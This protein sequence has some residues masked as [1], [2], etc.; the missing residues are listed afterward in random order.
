[1]AGWRKA[2]AGLAVFLGV[3]ALAVPMVVSAQTTT[4]WRASLAGINEVPSVTTTA[5]GTFTATLDETAGTLAWT[6]AV[7]NIT[8][9]TQAH[10]HSGAVG[11]N[12]PIVVNLFAAPASGPTSSINVSGTA[13]AADVIGPLAGNFAGLVSAIKAGTAYV[14]VHTSAN[15]GGEIRAQIGPGGTPTPTATATATATP[16]ATAT[17]KAATPTPTAAAATATV[18]AAPKSGTGFGGGDG[19][20]LLWTLG[21]LAVVS[22]GI[23]LGAGLL[24]RRR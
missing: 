3:T 15:A 9:A 11:V 22:A 1:M 18:I 10:I 13:R 8:A 2:I 5:T 12:G 14:N 6:L 17:A 16:T 4:Q 21:A 19:N 24:P 23:A 7:P 20:V